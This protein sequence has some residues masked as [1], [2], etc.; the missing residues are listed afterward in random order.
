MV[1]DFY[2]NV[3]QAFRP[4]GATSESVVA[5]VRSRLAATC[6]DGVAKDVRAPSPPAEDRP[7]GRQ[8]LSGRIAASSHQIERRGE[9]LLCF[10]CCSKAPAKRSRA[11]LASACTTDERF[12]ESRRGS[13]VRVGH[14]QVQSSHRH[15]YHKGLALHYCGVCGAIAR[16]STRVSLLRGLGGPCPGHASRSGRYALRCIL[17]GRL[18]SSLHSSPAHTGLA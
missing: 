7:H 1:P 13:D 6:L 15:S 5:S 12:Q 14:Q 18:P 3:K 9:N 17:Q 11:W 4:I 16:T 10:R 8:S 2:H